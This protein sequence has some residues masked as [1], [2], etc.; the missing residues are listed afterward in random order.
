[1]VSIA[2]DGKHQDLYLQTWNLTLSKQFWSNVIDIS[3]VGVKGT[4]Q[5]TSLLNYNT[6]PPQQPGANVQANRPYPTFGQM[7]ILDHH[8]ASIYN[9]LNIHFE[10]RFTHGLNFTTSY[11]FSHL[12]DNQGGDTN[13]VRNETQIPTAK[14]WANGLTDQRHNLTIAFVWMLPKFS[15]GDAAARAVVNGWGINGI[16]QFLAGN[17]LW[18]SQ[19]VDGENNGNPF[20]RPDLVPGQ[21]ETVPNRT[22]AEWFNTNAFT[23]AIGHYGSTPRNPAPIVSPSNNPLTL[24]VNRS[25]PMPWEGQHLDFRVEAFNALNHP[26]FGPPGSVQGTST[27]GVVTTTNSNNRELQ[28]ALKYFF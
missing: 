25:F 20:Q 17:P 4:D 12:L 23:P 16:Y 5:D 27:F 3:Y 18:I 21:A 10:H 14:E 6:G 2:A 15:G 1:V 22:I 19:S 7:R 9:G 24:A 28:L 13:G 26:E 8:G 11:S